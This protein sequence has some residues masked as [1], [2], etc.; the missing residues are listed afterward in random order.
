MNA[1]KIRL[2]CIFY[3]PNE[4]ICTE[5]GSAFTHRQSEEQRTEYTSL[6]NPNIMKCASLLIKLIVCCLPARKR[7]TSVQ[8]IVR[9][10]VQPEITSLPAGVRLL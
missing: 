3:K 7:K 2:F 8:Y 6:R 4:L 5:C 9:F 1:K 10:S